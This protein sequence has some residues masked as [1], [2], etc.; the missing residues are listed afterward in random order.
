[1]KTAA[2]IRRALTGKYGHKINPEI[3]EELAR[4][5]AQALRDGSQ[6]APT[7]PPFDV[8]WMDSWVAH[9]TYQS[10]RKTADQRTAELATVLRAMADLKFNERLGELTR[11]VRDRVRLAEPPDG[12]PPEPGTPPAG[13]ARISATPPDAGPPEPGAPPAGPASLFGRLGNLFGAPDGGPPEPGTPP[14]GPTSIFGGRIFAEPEPPDGG[15]P[16]PGVPPG[17]PPAPSPSPGPDGR[18][19]NENPWVL[20]WFV[21]LK[22]PE[23]LSVIDA[24]FTR[25]LRDLAVSQQRGA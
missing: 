13:P 12:G 10:G 11:F 4:D 22:A 8:G 17:P 7:Q 24:H 9:W 16:E 3:V 20:Y 18:V 19:L 5:L 25:R 21:S 6:P 14:A 23:L 15:P 2:D 1:M